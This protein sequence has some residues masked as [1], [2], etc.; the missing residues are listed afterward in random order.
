MNGP[1]AAVVLAAGGSTRFGA[2]KALA[3]IGGETLV[4]R[5][6][7]VVREGGCASVF[8]VVHDP[9]VGRTAEAAG[10]E[11]VP[12]PEWRLGISTSIARGIARAAA[13]L[14][15]DG[16]L[17]LAADQAQISPAD[18]RAL[19]EAFV[20]AVIA[21]AAD[22]GDGAFGVPAVFGRAAFPALLALEGDKGAK[23][24]LAANRERVQFVSMPKAAIDVDIPEDLI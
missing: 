17:I 10:A 6:V 5:A 3:R 22:Y 19:R 15:T 14:E 4:A 1:I 23:A 21:S 12:N 18:I 2:R 20:P 9:D 24:F 13:D 16:V 11:P 7:R 8:A